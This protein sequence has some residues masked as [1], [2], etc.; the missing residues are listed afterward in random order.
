[1][2]RGTWATCVTWGTTPSLLLLTSEATSHHI[3][4][5]PF[6]NPAR[7]S[8]GCSGCSALM[9]FSVSVVSWMYG[10]SGAYFSSQSSHFCSRSWHRG[11]HAPPPDQVPGKNCNKAWF[12]LFPPGRAQAMANVTCQRGPNTC[13]REE[14][15]GAKLDPQ[16]ASGVASLM[17]SKSTSFSFA[18]VSCV[19]RS[20]TSGTVA[21]NHGI[22]RCRV[23]FRVWCVDKTKPLEFV[24]LNKGQRCPFF[25]FQF[26]HCLIHADS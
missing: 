23:V 5:I 18:S 1:M 11:S 8:P 3:S 16:L 2:L 6:T 17:V 12:H 20:D 15:K 13:Q 22:A 10:P 26:L 25:T 21:G 14:E 4:P 9:A 24:A 19:S 7:C